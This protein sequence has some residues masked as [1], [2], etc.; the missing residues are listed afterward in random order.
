MDVWQWL[1]PRAGRWT[2]SRAGGGPHF[3]EAMP[4]RFRACTRCSIRVVPD[5]EEVL[6]WRERDRSICLRN[7]LDLDDQTWQQMGGQDRCGG[8]GC[9]DVRRGPRTKMSKLT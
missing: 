5:K 8:P 7:A 2:R 3:L 1:M 9:R 4:H 6:K